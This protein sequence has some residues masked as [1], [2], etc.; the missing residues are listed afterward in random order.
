MQKSTA[1]PYRGKI[2]PNFAEKSK[3]QAKFKAQGECE[4]GYHDEVLFYVGICLIA[5]FY[6]RVRITRPVFL[7]VL[8]TAGRE[9]RPP[10]II[11]K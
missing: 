8:V 2:C 3:R 6:R 5:V 1:L 7:T 9:T 10:T 11:C 4:I